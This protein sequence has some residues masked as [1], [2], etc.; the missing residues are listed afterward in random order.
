MQDL[1]VSIHVVVMIW[2]TVVER[3]THIRKHTHTERQ[4]LTSDI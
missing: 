2:A 4:F 1:H 3:H